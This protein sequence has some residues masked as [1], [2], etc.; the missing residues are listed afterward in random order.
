EP[1]EKIVSVITIFP[2]TFRGE[3]S[4]RF[5]LAIAEIKRRAPSCLNEAARVFIHILAAAEEQ[6]HR[7]RAA[8]VGNFRQTQ[9]PAWL[10][11][12]SFRSTRTRALIKF[13][14]LD[15][16]RLDVKTFQKLHGHLQNN[17]RHPK[18]RIIRAE[19]AVCRTN[20]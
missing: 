1:K 6:L 2:F 5:G 18:R 4:E 7:P 3:G 20:S 14:R 13:R 12:N 19:D 11:K 9:Q 10:A 8:L 17:R 15:L 16:P